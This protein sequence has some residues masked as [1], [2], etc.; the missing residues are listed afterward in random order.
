MSPR[1]LVHL[2]IQLTSTKSNTTHIW[3]QQIFLSKWNLLYSIIQIYCKTELLNLSKKY[4]EWQRQ[5]HILY[6]HVRLF[7]VDLNKSKF[8]SKVLMKRICQQNESFYIQLFKICCNAELLNL[9]NH[10]AWTICQNVPM[11]TAS[12]S[13]IKRLPK[14]IIL[15]SIIQ[16]LLQY[17]TIESITLCNWSNIPYEIGLMWCGYNCTIDFNNEINFETNFI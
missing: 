3:K 5:S 12:K 16:N 1:T 8:C 14:W 17:W 9:S 7:M 2:Y 4:S 11:P 6:K 10:S 15:Y 13:L